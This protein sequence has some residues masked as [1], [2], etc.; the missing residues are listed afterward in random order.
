MK[1]KHV[2]LSFYFILFFLLEI[3]SWQWTLNENKNHLHFVCGKKKA[4][5]NFMR[6]E[7]KCHGLSGS[8]TLRTCW[9]KL[10]LFRDVATRLKEKFDGAAKVIP[11]KSSSTSFVLSSDSECFHDL[12]QK[13]RKWRQDDHSGSGEYQTAGS[14]GFDLLGGIARFLQSG[15]S[16]RIA[17]H[18]RQGVQQ[19]VT[20]SRGLRAALLRAGL[21]NADDQDARQLSLSVQMVLRSHLQNLHRQE[22]RQHLPLINQ[23]H[24]QYHAQSSWECDAKMGRIILPLI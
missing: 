7:C 21:R 22:T 11:G 14:R 4:V 24:P 12:T 16:H 18:G 15:S 10:P 23:S 8:C 19:H 5:K 17:G 13:L 6:T 2:S 1:K 3:G 20:G 9:R